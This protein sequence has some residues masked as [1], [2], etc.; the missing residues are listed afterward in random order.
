MCFSLAWFQQLLVLLVIICAIV[1]IFKIL[2][3]Y[4]LSKLGATL[5]EGA[6]V[7]MAVLRIVVWAIVVIFVIYICFALISCLLSY[8]GGMPLLPRGR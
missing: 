5:G 8:S 2:V 6:N 4:A 1:A 7:V 3:P